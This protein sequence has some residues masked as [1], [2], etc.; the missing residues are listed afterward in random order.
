MA[1]SKELHE[2]LAKLEQEQER[3]L[4]EIETLQTIDFD[5]FDANLL[6]TA[7]VA[8]AKPIPSIQIPPPPKAKL[9][10]GYKIRLD[11]GNGAPASEWSEDTHGWRSKGQGSFYA[12]EHIAGKK[13]A[14]LKQRWPNYPLVMFSVD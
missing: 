4:Q 7:P 9:G 8:A 11:F 2:R 14:E 1:L 10:K 3:Q 13:L 5:S 6:A 12:N